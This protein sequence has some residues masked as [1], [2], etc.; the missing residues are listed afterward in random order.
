MQILESNC[1]IER[2]AMNI[3][4]GFNDHEWKQTYLGY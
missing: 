1:P 2:I 3:I 4:C